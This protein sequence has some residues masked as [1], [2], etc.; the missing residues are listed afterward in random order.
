MTPFSLLNP[1][2][3]SLQTVLLPKIL[4]GGLSLAIIL[5]LHV[6]E[7]LEALAS[8]EI[9]QILSS[10]FSTERFSLSSI[11]ALNLLRDSRLSSVDNIFSLREVKDMS[12]MKKNV[13]T[14]T[15]TIW[16]IDFYIYKSKW[17]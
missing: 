17:Q 1:S 11:F 5:R 3:L 4:S 8:R 16:K 7:Y 6:D 10:N 9:L 2:Q 13:S 15:S 12:P 14:A